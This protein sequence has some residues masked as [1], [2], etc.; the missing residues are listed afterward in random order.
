M[1]FSELSP[2]AERKTGF[3]NKLHAFRNKKL[4]AAKPEIDAFFAELSEFDDENEISTTAL[5]SKKDALIEK[6]DALILKQTAKNNPAATLIIATLFAVKLEIFSRLG[7]IENIQKDYINLL[8]NSFNA[9]ALITQEQFTSFFNLTLKSK[10][11]EVIGKFSQAFDKTDSAIK[12]IIDFESASVPDILTNASI[13]CDATINDTDIRN[14]FHDLWKIVALRPLMIYSAFC[15]TGRS[16]NF[17]GEIVID[18][19]QKL[20]IIFLGSSPESHE[21]LIIAGKQLSNLILV[22]TTERDNSGT[23]PIQ[24]S[25]AKIA[26]IMIHELH[27]LWESRFF[28]IISIPIPT[29]DQKNLTHF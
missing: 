20:K 24:Y 8:R 7:E 15:A 12:G 16:C 13:N 10:H 19:A 11:S 5:R 4:L 2:Y 25:S 22:S 29:I 27:H 3:K 14:I 1:K 23:L 6:C 9:S 17:K 28:E 18:E 21:N 26:S